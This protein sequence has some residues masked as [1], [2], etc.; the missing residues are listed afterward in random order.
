MPHSELNR[1]LI[2]PAIVLAAAL[3]LSGCAALP[4]FGT[5]SG[6]SNNSSSRDDDDEDDDEDED[7][8]DE[9]EESKGGSSGCPRELLDASRAS[10]NAGDA[11]LDKIE[12]TEITPEQFEPSAIGTVVDEGCFFVVEYESD[13]TPAQIFEAFV[14]GGAELVAELD[15]ALTDDGFSNS[16]ASFYVGDDNSFVIVTTSEGSSYI[17]DQ[18]EDDGLDFLGDEWVLIMAYKGQV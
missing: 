18:L 5:D 17:E 1:L 4:F 6:S 2:L 12:I 14:P 15:S 8:E 9:D 7:D 3:S 13:G 16:A 11:A 10:A